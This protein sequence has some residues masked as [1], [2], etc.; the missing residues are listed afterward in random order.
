LASDRRRI[1][2]M[3]K[4]LSTKKRSIPKNTVSDCAKNPWSSAMPC[5]PMKIHV[6]W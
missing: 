3:R 6:T 5:S 4:P 2:P 1:D